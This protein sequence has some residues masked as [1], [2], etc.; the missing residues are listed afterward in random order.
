MLTV[1]YENK[2]Y[3]VH[4][5][6]SILDSLLRN[7]I[8]IP[9][10]CQVGI[11]HSCLMHVVEGKIPS[12][13]QKGLPK[14]YQEEKNFLPCICK[15]LE[16]MKIERPLTNSKILNTSVISIEKK[17][18]DILIL[19]LKCDES[20][21]YKPG[22]FINLINNQNL[23]RSYS[24]ASHPDL[25]SYLELHIKRCPKGKM[26]HWIFEE[27]KVEDNIKIS[28]PNG[29]CFYMENSNHKPILLVG[30]GTGL[31]PLVGILQDAFTKK[32]NSAIHLIHG[33]LHSSG[34]Y[35]KNELY[36]FEKLNK[37]FKFHPC[38]LNVDQNDSD[39]YLTSIQ[40]YIENNFPVLSDWEVFICGNEEFVREIEQQVFLQGAI[41]E[42]IHSDAFIKK[43]SQM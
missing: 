37:N 17:L 32:H 27:L 33:S 25:N 36:E 21:K 41:F 2:K 34:I 6:E 18:D 15:P 23:S 24:L 7:N 1:E 10:S 13:S 11:C 26:S 39:I 3:L 12:E 22:Q 14:T 20:F 19:K 30:V 4:E 35:L 16:N 28:G 9:Y 38:A 8:M 29:Y 31:S 5:N 43:K 40:T 42:N